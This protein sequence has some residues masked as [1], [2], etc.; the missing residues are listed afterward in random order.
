MINQYAPAHRFSSDSIE[1]AHTYIRYEIDRH[2]KL[3]PYTSV[4]YSEP[5]ESAAIYATEN[6]HFVIIAMHSHIHQ[7]GWV[8]SV[9][10]T[11]FLT[12]PA[13]LSLCAAMIEVRQECAH[14]HDAMAEAF[15]PAMG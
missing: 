1:T 7:T 5:D 11:Y 9:P 4:A 14:I 8:R 12:L 10:A 2:A 3:L 13:I 6:P 15:L